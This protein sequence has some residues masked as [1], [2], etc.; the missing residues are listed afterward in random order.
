MRLK[1]NRIT[2]TYSG[3]FPDF[4]LLINGYLPGYYYYYCRIKYNVRKYNKLGFVCYVQA[5]WK[6]VNNI[7][8]LYIL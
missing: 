4:N 5:Y 7:I 6:A 1:R 3:E 2:T 8:L